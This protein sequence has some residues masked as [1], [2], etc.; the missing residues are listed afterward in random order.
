MTFPF[1]S[2]F[3]AFGIANTDF[4]RSYE[5]DQAI[6]VFSAAG[7][8]WLSDFEVFNSV[9]EGLQ[10]EA[11]RDA[12]ELGARHVSFGLELEMRYGL[13]PH[14]T[15]IRSPRI[16]IASAA[17]VAEVYQAFEAEYAR[18]YSPAA[19]YLAG[20]VEILGFT[21]WSAIRTRKLALPVLAPAA[22]ALEEAAK[23]RRP[24]FW[25]PE[26]GWVDTPVYDLSLLGPGHGLEGPVLLDGA[27]VTVVV[28]GGR[29]FRVDDRGNGV[30]ADKN[31]RE[32]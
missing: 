29:G 32:D 26:R 9:V 10:T 31:E 18:I 25:G 24:A 16:R 15:R 8:R 19:T 13:Q 1:G 14:V 30:I 6:K 27:D 5:R 7:A 22:R 4:V 28:D 17:D 3:S 21:L 20:G 12:E 2:V 23:G 11:L